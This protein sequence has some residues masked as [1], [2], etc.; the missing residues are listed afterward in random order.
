MKFPRFSR[1]FVALVPLAAALLLP[2]HSAS[3]GDCCAAPETA[4]VAAPVAVHLLSFAAVP[5][6]PWL[7]Q[8]VATAGRP[9]TPKGSRQ[10]DYMFE[11]HLWL[12]GGLQTVPTGLPLTAETSTA[13][14]NAFSQAGLGVGYRLSP[15][16]R[17]V[18]NWK[19]GLGQSSVSPGSQFTVGVALRY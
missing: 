4:S 14:R 16:V 5:D 10:F 7:Y 2:A 9:G 12:M 18:T 6:A 8:P 1:R 3:A 15:A 19:T 11:R 17:A 13:D